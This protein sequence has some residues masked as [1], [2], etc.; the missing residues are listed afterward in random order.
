MEKWAAARPDAEALVF[1]EERLTWKDFKDSMDA[2]ARAYLEAGIMKGDRVAL[3]SM[4]RTEFL[5]T[6]MAAGKVG[7]VWLGLS[8][9]VHP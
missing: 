6:Y 1:G 2:V 7:A 4:A 3:L 9:K 5:T 8:P